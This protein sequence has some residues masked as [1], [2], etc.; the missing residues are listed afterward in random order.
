MKP[1]AF[2]PSSDP[3]RIK[4]SS[5]APRA[6]RRT[7]PLRVTSPLA[8]ATALFLCAALPAAADAQP[9][10]APSVDATQLNARLHAAAAPPTLPPNIRLPKLPSSVLHT[11]F[12][13]EVNKKGQVTRVRSGKASSNPGFNMKTYGN[14]LQAFIR[15]QSGHS[16]PGIF[17][18]TYDYSPETKMVVRNV[19]L[20]RRGGVNVN[21]PGAV[22]AMM[23]ASRKHVSPT[24]KAAKPH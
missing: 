19:A 14:A 17:R 4:W 11:E 1:A 16:V 13:V 24:P 21:A 6:E 22:E 23:E 7:S 10:S 5:R 20:I 3:R 15:T 8:L 12:V 9:S 18:L 2:N